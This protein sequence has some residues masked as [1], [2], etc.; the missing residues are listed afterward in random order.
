[1]LTPALRYIFMFRSHC[2][3]NKEMAKECR[4]G[5]GKKELWA[6]SCEFLKL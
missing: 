6:D 2:A 4:E 3:V 1:M 5:M